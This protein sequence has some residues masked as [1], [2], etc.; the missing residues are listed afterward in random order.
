M[1]QT[2]EF[3]IVRFLPKIRWR[4]ILLILVGPGVFVIL[5]VK[6]WTLDLTSLLER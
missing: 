3:V 2:L 1:E 5:L 4:G 6:S